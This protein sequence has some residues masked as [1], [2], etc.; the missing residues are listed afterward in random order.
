MLTGIADSRLAMNAVAIQIRDRRADRQQLTELALVLKAACAPTKVRLVLNGDRALAS[1][2]SLHGV[3][4][5]SAQLR[6]LHQP[7]QPD[8]P[9]QPDHPAESNPAHSCPLLGASC[10]SFEELLLAEAAGAQYAVLGPIFDTPSKRPYGAP[11]GV[12]AIELAQ[13]R[14]EQLKLFVLAL[15]GINID[16]GTQALTAGADGL[17][18]IRSFTTSTCT[19]QLCNLVADQ[20]SPRLPPTDSGLPPTLR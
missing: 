17:A 15:G 7:D 14:P 18:A 1:D 11:L 4:L 9:N 2:L 10:H 20:A 13:G 6:R 8:Q 5:T 19:T 16:T 12:R 3:H